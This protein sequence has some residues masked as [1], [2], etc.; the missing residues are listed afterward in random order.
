MTYTFKN[1]SS[2]DIDEV[3]VFGLN[4]AE[5]N[6]DPDDC[7]IDSMKLD[8][9]DESREASAEELEEINGNRSFMHELIVDIVRE[10]P[11]EG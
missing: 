11:G 2:Y 7:A 4:S 5:P 9:G 10:L 6:P 3:V 1:G 8:D